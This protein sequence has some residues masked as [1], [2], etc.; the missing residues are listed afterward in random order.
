MLLVMD[1]AMHL[2]GALPDTSPTPRPAADRFVPVEHVRL[3]TIQLLSR[4][5]DTEHPE[6]AYS[7]EDPDDTRA[8]PNLPVDR[9]HFPEERRLSTTLRDAQF[10]SEDGESH[11][12]S[13]GEFA[14]LYLSVWSNSLW[15]AEVTGAASPPTPARPTPT[16]PS[17][18]TRRCRRRAAS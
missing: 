9:L 14:A 3:D 5:T 7:P 15:G 11:M 4:P 17:A 16:A 13:L 1:R 2:I 18:G 10:T 12:I 8:D 6:R